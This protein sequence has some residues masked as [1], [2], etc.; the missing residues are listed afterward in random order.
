MFDT[1]TT[2]FCPAY[3]PDQ[4]STRSTRK[5]SLSPLLLLLLLLLLILL[6]IRLD[7]A[8]LVKYIHSLAIVIGTE[9]VVG[10]EK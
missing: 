7:L 10:R 2:L 6:L 4:R 1:A 8:I 9:F 3:Y 5:S